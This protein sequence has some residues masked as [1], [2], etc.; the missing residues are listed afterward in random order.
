MDCYRE[1]K[2]RKKEKIEEAKKTINAM[3]N[4]VLIGNCYEGYEYHRL[5]DALEFLVEEFKKVK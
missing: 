3:A 1:E 5:Q 2:A 4:R